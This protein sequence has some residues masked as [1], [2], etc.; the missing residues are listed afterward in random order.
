MPGFDVEVQGLDVLQRRLDELKGPTV[1]RILN[2][3][4][5]A[6]GDVFKAAIE[7]RTPVREDLASGT[8]LP[9][10]ALRHDIRVRTLSTGNDNTA[11]VA[12]GPGSLTSHVMRW[13][14]WGH[15]MVKGGYS[16]VLASGRTRGP[17]VQTTLVPAH[18]VMRPAYEAVQS[19]ALEAVV[20]TLREELVRKGGK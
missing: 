7:E 9:P 10:D 8:A 4:L 2:T 5:R 19:E 3:A 16:K 20:V 13:L 17:G 6:G 15:R 1:K 12:V 14:E 11:A 18:P